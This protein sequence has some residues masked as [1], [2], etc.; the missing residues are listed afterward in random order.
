[1]GK[2]F[3]LTA[4]SSRGRSP[5]VYW[6][7]GMICKDKWGKCLSLQMGYGGLIFGKVLLSFLY[8]DSLC[9]NLY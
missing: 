3:I 5:W 8:K 9:S 4:G 2:V 6:G 7:W 1:M